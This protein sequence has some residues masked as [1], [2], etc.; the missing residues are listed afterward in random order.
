MTRPRKGAPKFTGESYRLETFDD[1]LK[2]PE[3]CIE[4]CTR[5]L[6]ICLLVGYRT[7]KLVQAHAE[8]MGVKPGDITFRFPAFVWTD[9]D[10]RSVTIDICTPDQAPEESAP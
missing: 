3:Q 9:D 7:V 5:E 1:L 4:R 2:V 10:E 8:G 6:V